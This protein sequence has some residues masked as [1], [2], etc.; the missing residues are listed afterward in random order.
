M[1]DSLAPSVPSSVIL[2][3][4]AVGFIQR[5]KRFERVSRCRLLWHDRLSSDPASGLEFSVFQADLGVIEENAKC[6]LY[7]ILTVI[8]SGLAWE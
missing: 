4:L 7:S 5:K 1:N 6:A 8:K 3:L 2:F